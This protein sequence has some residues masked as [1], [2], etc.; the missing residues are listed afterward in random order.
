MVD[1]MDM[2]DIINEH[3]ASFIGQIWANSETLPKIIERK[4]GLIKKLIREVADFVEGQQTIKCKNCDRIP[5]E[6]FNDTRRIM[7]ED[8]D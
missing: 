5:E 8:Y 3:L 7:M 4:K 2:E 1:I 6:S